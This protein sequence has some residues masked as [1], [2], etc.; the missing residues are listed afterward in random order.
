VRSDKLVAEARGQSG[1][2]E[3]GE[4]PTLKAATKQQLVK[5]D[6]IFMCAAVTL[7]SGVCNLVRLS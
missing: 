3:K 7:I 2:P 1:N 5:T 4:R 6:K